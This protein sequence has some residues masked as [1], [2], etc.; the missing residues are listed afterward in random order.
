MFNCFGKTFLNLI[1]N[2]KV[3]KNLLTRMK[4]SVSILILI[5]VSFSFFAFNDSGDYTV[6]GNVIKRNGGR[7]MYQVGVINIMFKNQISGFA[8]NSV[9]LE[10]IDRVF[11]EI[12]VNNVWQMH[13]LK[14]DVSK[15]MIGDDQ[16][17]RVFQIKYD[18]S[19]DPI[20]AANMVL[21]DNK[22]LIEWAEP[23]FV[24]ESDF[25]PND[26]QLSGQW[27]IQKINSYQAWDLSK[28]DTSVTIGIVD[29]GSDLD[30]P[31]IS[32]NIKRNWLEI[33]GNGIDDDANGYIDDYQGWDFYGNDNNPQIQPAGNTHGSHVSGCASQVT[34][35]S[36]HGGGIGYKTKLL[37][38]KH[39]DDSNPESL[40]YNTDNG[41][42]YCYQ[43]GA[44]V[45]NCSYG[46][47]SYSSYT[48]LVCTNAWNNGT[49]ICASAGNGDA[50][51]V[52]QN[53]ARYPASYDNVVSVAASTSGDIK[54]TFSNFHSTVDITG[55]GDNILSTIYNDTYTNL[56]GTSMSSPIVAGTV[57]L[58]RAKYPTWTATQVLTR[59][60]LGVDSI[61]NLNP[62]YIDLLG[63]GRVNAFKCLSDF[64]IVKLVT[65]YPNDSIYGNNDKVFDVNEIIAIKMDL[66]NTHFAGTNASLRLT[67]TSTDVQI[68]QDSVYVGSIGAYASFSTALTNTFKVKALSSCAFDKDITF[69]VSSSATCYTDDNANTFTVKFRQGFAV[70]TL[71]NMKL[72]LTS[73]G[74]VG[75]KAQTYG[76]GLQIGTGI[77]NNLYEGGLMI[78]TGNTKVSDV[79]RRGQAPANASDTDFVAMQNYSILTP[80]VH[81]GQDGS[82]KFN[83]NG[84]GTNKIGVEVEAFSYAFN[85]GPDVDYIL[86]QYKI[87]NTNATALSNV[88]AGLFTWMSPEGNFSTGNISRLS[89]ANKLAYTYNTGVANRYLGVGLMTNQTMNFKIY[90]FGDI[91]NGFTTQEKWDGLSSGVFNDSLGPGGNPFV[92]AA[93]PFNLAANQVETIGFAILN[94]SSAADLI[95]KNNQ[96]KL[97][98]GTVG[99]TNISVEIPSVFSLSQNYPNPFN[100]TTNI[101]FGVPK[102]SLVTI[103]V[104]DLLGREV[105]VLLNEQKQA[106][107]YQVDFNASSLSSG[108]YFYRMQ[109]GTF[110]DI[111]R[112]VVI[113]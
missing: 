25:I 2:Y 88:Y 42:V 33:P 50:N 72:C 53:W 37:I 67:T 14:A 91:I 85:T 40:L 44:K 70:H 78:G 54:T 77:L 45:I 20:D 81:S 21:K 79:V 107:T 41:I 98:Y 46:T 96:A 24:Y 22:D 109:A 105:A 66:K 112:M 73:D 113:K 83:D 28:G 29:S 32:A 59:L 6:V 108:V 90:T 75:K 15:R 58:I 84:A 82:G 104:Y 55:P 65:A 64:P 86:V 30:H 80:G 69:K 9:G 52:G 89:T 76:T 68:V 26:P 100:P 34:N 97:K 5:S 102:N 92:M 63:T 93:G 60:K 110:A 7:T 87:K 19:V 38:S 23:S 47:S 27:H 71:N 36:V 35:N 111:K 1:N 61:Y 31:D 48:Q 39:T 106:G 17:S 12:S 4:M 57:A 3:M 13:P 10:K 51:G 94:G 43:N 99:V 74:N 18:R 56:S 101:Q 8:K 62:S 16:L 103:K 49:V 95:V 11:T